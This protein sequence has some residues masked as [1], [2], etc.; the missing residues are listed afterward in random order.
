MLDGLHA[1]RPRPDRPRAE[2]RPGG[3]RPAHRRA[4]PIAGASKAPR[5]RA[6]TCYLGFDL[7]GAA[8]ADEPRTR[9]PDAHASRWCQHE[10]G[11][12]RPRWSPTPARASPSSPR[13]LDRDRRAS[14]R[15]SDN[16]YLD[17]QQLSRA[18]CSATTC[19]PTCCCSAP[20]TSAAACR[21]RAA[22]LEQAIRLNGAA[23]ETNL[24]AFAGAAR[25]W[26]TPDARRGGARAA[27]S[28][29]APRARR[30]RARA[31]RRSRSTAT[32]ASCAGCSRCACPSS[33]PTRTPPT[34]RATP[35]RCA[36]VARGRAER[37]PG[38]RRRWPRP[39]RATCTS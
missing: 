20:P 32:A 37:A 25:R 29:R 4:T 39:S 38:A 28:R 31:R 30:G 17:A 9:R 34:P 1:S 16:L 5:R 8:S 35:R 23:V 3:L 27:P 10:R 19:R 36:A 2:G 13:Q 7:L 33:S 24:A 12:D 14:T 15:A 6:S 18:R 26:P 11:A 21:S 22:A